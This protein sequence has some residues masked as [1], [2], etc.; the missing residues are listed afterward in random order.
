MSAPETTIVLCG[1][2]INYTHLPI[3]T[4]LSNAMVPVNGKPVIGWILD[5]L[6]KRGANRIV[7]VL[8]E[9]DQRLRLFLEWAYSCRA[10]L[11]LVVAPPGGTIVESLLAALQSIPFEVDGPTRIVLGDTLI[12]DPDES[13][14]EDFVR[15]GR[16]EVSRRWCV[17][18]VTEQRQ[19]VEYR[20]KVEL[21]GGP[22]VALAG[23]YYLRDGQ[24]L[25]QMALRSA[26]A[27]E[28]E[29]SDILRR[30]SAV[31]PIYAIPAHEWY[32]FG[33]IDNLV[34]ARLR[35]LRP[36][37]FNSLRIDPVLHTITKRSQNSGKLRDELDWYLNLPEDLK[38]L[39]PRIVRADET[40][41]YLEI[42]QEYYGY[43]TLADLYIYADLQLDTWL[44]ILR[45]VI[46]VHNQ[47]RRYSGALE[48]A[49][50]E[51]IYLHKTFQRI[52]QLRTFGAG[53]PE[54][55]DRPSIVYNGRE[56]ESLHRL[57]PAVRRRVRRVI[58]QAPI[59]IIHGDLC[60]SNILFDVSNYVVRVIDPRGRFGRKGIYGDARYDL[61][62][63]R[64]SIHGRYDYIVSDLFELHETSNG[65][66][67][68]I[69]G[70]P[71]QQLLTDAFDR[72]LVEQGYDASDI[73]F[74]EG[75]LFV[76]M[77]PLHS[78]YPLRQQMM[79]LTG[80]TLLNEEL[81]CG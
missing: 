79:Y 36:R 52:E 24:M 37:Y 10:Q 60:F 18:D 70:D 51:A 49:D 42:V 81:R 48:E 21:S 11:S 71:S 76:S 75:L 63:L 1:G 50:L 56:L 65:F 29:L 73:R 58:R 47:F 3:G 62:K 14:D 41:G 46:R 19:I 78:D 45:Q 23:H 13:L 55:L 9:V 33:H 35:L 20:D 31:Y 67:G 8:R 32:D 26:E 64:H 27:H 59:T 16:V 6:L 69:F 4:S 17:V 12:T 57:W 44:S 15:V 68:R 34:E 5:D 39:A 28:R 25:R 80:L 38:V 66:T 74:I 7:V 72:M 61:A 40:A 43:P 53:W 22:Y 77:L 2:S 30:Y 54:L